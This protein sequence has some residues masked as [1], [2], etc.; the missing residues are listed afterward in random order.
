MN[1]STCSRPSIALYRCLV[2]HLD[3]RGVA[4]LFT[5]TRRPGRSV[6]EFIEHILEVGGTCLGIHVGVRSATA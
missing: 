5:L 1:A 6:Y 3:N 4:P 2:K